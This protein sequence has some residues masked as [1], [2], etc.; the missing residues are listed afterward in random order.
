MGKIKNAVFDYGQ[1][2][3]KYDP[4][5]IVGRY[6]EDKADAEILERVVFDR[7][8]HDRL[9]EGIIT[10]DFAVADIKSRLPERLHEKAEM[11]YYAWIYNIP[12][13]PGMEELVTEIR[14]K[15]GVR[16][17]LLSNI[18]PYFV[19]HKDEMPSLSLFEK[20]IF[21]CVYK[22]AKP[23]RRIYEILTSECE[24]KAEE[25][26]FIDDN[27]KNIDAAIDFGITG[28]LFDGDVGKLR[29]YLFK[30]LS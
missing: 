22:V 13:I 28:Y 19:E 7:I 23:D 21:S 12:K 1:V 18:S 17:F 3:I 11:L 26:V 30:L 20:C 27:K 4:H 16:V 9:D 14:E 15:F 8:Y 24:I 25:T 10:D 5:Y 2:M 29:E 6:I